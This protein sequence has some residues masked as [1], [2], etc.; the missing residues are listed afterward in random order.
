MP[1]WEISP[2]ALADLEGIFNFIATDAPEAAERMAEE[3]FAAFE[4]LA[5]WPRSGHNRSDLTKRDVRFWPVRPYLVVYRERGNGVQIAAILHGSRDV[6][7]VLDD[8]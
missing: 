1:A 2:D 6:P 8:R 3:L 4:Q 5:A 7:S